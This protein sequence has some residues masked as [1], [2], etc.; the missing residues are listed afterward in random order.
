MY[1]AKELAPNLFNSYGEWFRNYK[2][3][4]GREPSSGECAEAVEYFGKE[5]IKM[6]NKAELFSWKEYEKALMEKLSK[7]NSNI[8]KLKILAGLTEAVTYEL[9]LE[10]KTKEDEQNG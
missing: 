9:E 6:C 8:D 10:Q 5:E 3:K 7:S 1:Y 2:D 4:A